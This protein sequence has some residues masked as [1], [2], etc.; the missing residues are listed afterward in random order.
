MISVTIFICQQSQVDHA[1]GAPRYEGQLLNPAEYQPHVPQVQPVPQRKD[2][3]VDQVAVTALLS[4]SVDMLR[5]SSSE[6]A[7]L[8]HCWYCKTDWGELVEVGW[9]EFNAPPDTV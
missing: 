8:H 3:Y 4:C 5:D 1:P 2:Q 6:L 7:V 9:A